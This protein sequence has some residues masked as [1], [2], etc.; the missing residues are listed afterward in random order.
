M[1]YIFPL[2]ISKYGVVKQFLGIIRDVYCCWF[3]LLATN[4]RANVLI[5]I[6][7]KPS[8]SDD[9]YGFTIQSNSA[10]FKVWM[11]WWRLLLRKR[12]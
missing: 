7:Y 1:H 2:T 11:L 6:M 5:A 8:G 3:F 10:D 12:T 4:H 9:P